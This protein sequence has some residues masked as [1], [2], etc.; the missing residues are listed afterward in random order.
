[1]RKYSFPLVREISFVERH[2]SQTC[3]NMEG[4]LYLIKPE[5]S[6][7]RKEIVSIRGTCN[8]DLFFFNAPTVEKRIFLFN[9]AY[10]AF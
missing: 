3:N 9:T 6:E 8:T 10:T 7:A 5:N 1:M 2:V 4:H